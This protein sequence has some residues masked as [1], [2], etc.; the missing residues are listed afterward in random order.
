MGEMDVGDGHARFT[1]ALGQSSS[2]LGDTV[3]V[4]DDLDG[5]GEPD[6]AVAAVAG[7]PTVG[8][9]VGLFVDV[10]SGAVDVPTTADALLTV[11]PTQEWITGLR[12]GDVDGD[13]FGD[14]VLGTVRMDAAASAGAYLILGGSAGPL[15][16]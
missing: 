12:S 16:H 14:L 3:A 6:L 2:M 11:D 7:N 15:I 9:Y 8:P 1:D 10:P 5:D 4:V 13:G